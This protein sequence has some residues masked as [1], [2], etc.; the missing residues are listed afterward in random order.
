[1]LYISFMFLLSFYIL[2]HKVKALWLIDFFNFNGFLLNAVFENRRFNK[3][4]HDWIK[5]LDLERK[6]SKLNQIKDIHKKNEYKSLSPNCSIQQRD[7]V[8]LF[9]FMFQKGHYFLF[10][11]PGLFVGKEG[12]M[13]HS[14]AIIGAG[15]PQVCWHPFLCCW[16]KGKEKIPQNGGYLFFF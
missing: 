12:P 5:I 2:R 6:Q 3:N 14:G 15:V 7:I 11:M 4:F 1:M 9:K 8:M 13:I 16:K 10:Y